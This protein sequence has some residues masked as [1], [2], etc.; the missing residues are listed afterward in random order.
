MFNK[1]F[2][3]FFLFTNRTVVF[4]DLSLSGLPNLW[5]VSISW[6]STETSISAK[7]NIADSSKTSS[8]TD[9]GIPLKTMLFRRPYCA[10]ALWPDS[11]FEHRFYNRS[12]LCLN[13]SF[14]SCRFLMTIS[15]R[16]MISSL[17]GLIRL[18]IFSVRIHVTNYAFFTWMFFY[19]IMEDN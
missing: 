2:L 8:E 5:Q 18:T 19:A 14:S 13:F 16:L 1:N 15:L 7:S 12:H 4:F 9:S 17:R 3:Q 10:K 11:Y 6:L